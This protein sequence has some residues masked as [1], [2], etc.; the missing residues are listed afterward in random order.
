MIV[1]NIIRIFV[2]MIDNND[3][4]NDNDITDNTTDNT[5]D[6][7]ILDELFSNFDRL[8]YISQFNPSMFGYQLIKKG[9]Y[10]YISFSGNRRGKTFN[11]SYVLIDNTDRRLKYIKDIESMVEVI[12]SLDFEVVFNYLRKNR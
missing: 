3:N 11:V 2:T 8:Q 5:T 6:D 4:N 10:N 9:S 1:S 7:T 12:N